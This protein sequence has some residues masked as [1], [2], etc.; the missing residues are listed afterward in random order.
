MAHFWPR[1]ELPTFSMS[2]QETCL[3]DS[4]GQILPNYM[5]S[6]IGPNNL[7]FPS[8][9]NSTITELKHCPRVAREKIHM[10]TP[11]S[12]EKPA[13]PEHQ[14]TATLT[15]FEVVLSNRVNIF[16]FSIYEYHGK[17]PC[18]V[19]VR[20]GPFLRYGRILRIAN[21]EECPNSSVQIAMFDYDDSL[22]KYLTE[23]KGLVNCMLQKFT[24]G[25]DIVVH[26][27]EIV[28][29]RARALLRIRVDKQV[30]NQIDWL[31]ERLIF[32]FCMAIEVY[33]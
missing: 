1:R 16:A 7:F 28:S 29:Y 26:D 2:N 3:F 12:V 20:D 10:E 6:E 17:F 19:V 4:I 18:G 30:V 21:Q 24:Y 25:T 23:L 31:V 5:I 8:E 33:D 14:E 15:C 22:G 32:I 11:K 27:F 13:A 9:P